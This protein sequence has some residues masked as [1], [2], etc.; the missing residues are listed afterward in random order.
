[1]KLKRVRLEDN[2]ISVAILL[3]DQWKPLVPWLQFYE[4]SGHRPSPQ[5]REAAADLVLFLMHRF[6][7]EE[8]LQQFLQFVETAAERSLPAVHPDA[9]LPFNP[10][11]FRDFMLWERHFI[12]SKLGLIQRF[13]PGAARILT[14]YQKLTGKPHP[15]LKPP[16]MFYEVPVY[17]MGNHI[18]FY[19]DGAEV[20]WPAYSNALDYEL[21]LGIV[22]ARPVYNANP[23][24]ALKAV[25]GFTILNDFSARDQ[26]VKEF[27]ESPFGP[28]VKAKNFGTALAGVV[29]TADE[30][31]PKLETLVGRV[32]VNGE[33]WSEGSTAG[34]AHSIGDV[35]AYASLE[36]RLIPGELLGTGTLPGCAGVEIGRW[37]QPGDTVRLEVEGI[38]T[39]ENRV[40]P[41]TD[42]L[43]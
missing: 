31:F 41:S 6:E 25:G 20:S 13:K 17:Y 22:I 8:E 24:E 36:E 15:K 27:F 16:K 33:L 12:Q 2:S 1:M 4:E 5:L 32:Y 9:L 30:L 43:S 21:E 11:S 38:G 7:I 39:L 29:V 28:V 42:R 14:A 23:E 34:M 3:E 26:Q 35:V 40:V 19:P 18:Q 37:L 10:L